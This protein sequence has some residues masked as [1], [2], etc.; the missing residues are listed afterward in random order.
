MGLYSTFVF[1]LCMYGIYFF[2]F[3]LKVIC[4]SSVCVLLSFIR[5]IYIYNCI[6]IIVIFIGCFIY[7]CFTVIAIGYK[8]VP[9]L[10]FDVLVLVFNHVPA[11]LLNLAFHVFNMFIVTWNYIFRYSI[12]FIIY[13][14]QEP[15]L[16]DRLGLVSESHTTSQA[17]TS[18]TNYSQRDALGIYFILIIM[19]M[20]IFREPRVTHRWITLCDLLQKYLKI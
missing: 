16:L 14:F 15:S 10:N 7:S 1:Q 11:S 18:K 17:L 9:L 4:F 3:N 2:Y 5:N 19:M 12:I 20:A 6:V 8:T 13:T